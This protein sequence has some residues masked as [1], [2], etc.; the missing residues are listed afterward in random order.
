MA[1]IEERSDSD[2]LMICRLRGVAQLGED[3]RL[4]GGGRGDALFRF[5]LDG[6]WWL[7]E[8]RLPGIQ[9]VVNWGNRSSNSSSFLLSVKWLSSVVTR[10]CFGKK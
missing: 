10:S 8:S 3:K 6:C 1:L 9:A 2:A 7:L 5:F 4:E